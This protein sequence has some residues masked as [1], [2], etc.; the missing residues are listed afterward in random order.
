[1]TLQDMIFGFALSMLKN[2]QDAED[3][4]QDIF[5]NFVPPICISEMHG[6]DD[7]T[8]FLFDEIARK[9]KKSSHRRKMLEILYVQDNTNRVVLEAAFSIIYEERRI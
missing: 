3:R 2:K 1:M 6:N 8:Q 4:S 5:L 7:D 9:T